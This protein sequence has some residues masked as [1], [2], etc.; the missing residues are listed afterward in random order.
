[1]LIDVEESSTSTSQERRSLLSQDEK[2]AA[3]AEK[4]WRRKIITWVSSAPF[5]GEWRVYLQQDVLL[6]GVSLAL[7]F[8]TVL[9]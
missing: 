1:M 8:F 2:N 4:S 7:L 9:R 5:V 3:L 6:S